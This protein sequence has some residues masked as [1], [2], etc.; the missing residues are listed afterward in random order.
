MAL[1]IQAIGD[2]PLVVRPE[3]VAGEV[4]LITSGLF[5]GCSGVIQRRQHNH[6]LVVNLPVLGQSVSTVVPLEIAELLA[7]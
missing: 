4:V 6:H 5:S 3:L 2:A 7:G 1:L